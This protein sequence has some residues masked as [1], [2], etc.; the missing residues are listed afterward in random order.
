MYYNKITVDHVNYNQAKFIL[1]KL[2]SQRRIN[3]IELT[4]LI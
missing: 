1:S 4:E 3:L 2:K